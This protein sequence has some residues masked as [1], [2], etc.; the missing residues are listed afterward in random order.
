MKVRNGE[1]A[2]TGTAVLSGVAL[3]HDS[4]K[5]WIIAIFE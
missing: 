3:A 1:M 4:G 2:E 5:L